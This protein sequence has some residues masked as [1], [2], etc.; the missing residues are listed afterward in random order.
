MGLLIGFY[1]FIT[2]KLIIRYIFKS[3]KPVIIAGF[4]LL[5]LVIIG[6]I[7]YLLHKV[8]F[9][10]LIPFTVGL[11]VAPMT[12]ITGVMLTGKKN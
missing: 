2:W 9:F 6:L 11:I 12:I 7:L 1:P 5:K 4:I 10:R 8:T 3:G